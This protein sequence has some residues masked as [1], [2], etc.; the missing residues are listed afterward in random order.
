MQAIQNLPWWAKAAFAFVL[1]AAGVSGFEI[2]G[3]D[4]PLLT[5]SSQQSFDSQDLR[6]IAI[7]IHDRNTSQ[8][9]E[10]VEIQIIFDGPPVRKMTDRNGYTEIDIP[11]RDSVQLILTHQDYQTARESINLNTDPNTNRIL[12]M[13]SNTP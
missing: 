5:Q 4:F 13:D 6:N 8:P 7:T 3:E 12:Y 9:I 1:I 2:L 11:T 10:S